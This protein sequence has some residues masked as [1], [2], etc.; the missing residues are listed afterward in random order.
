[1]S[2]I[3]CPQIA[4][5]Q[6][7]IHYLL[8]H[9][10][11][12]ELIDCPP[13]TN[14]TIELG[15]SLSP[16]FVCTPFKFTLGCMIESIYLGADT[17]IQM[18]GGCRYGYY[19]EL[20]EQII[21]DLGHEV[22]VYNLITAGK[23][24][25]K[26]IYNIFKEINP[27]LNI[28]KSLYYITITINMI[29]CM[30]KIDDFIRKNIGFE[31]NKN[32]FINLKKQMLQDFDKT[33]SNIN[34]FITYKKYQR[35]FKKLPINKSKDCLKIGIIGELYTVMEPFS[36]Y[37]IEYE[38]AKFNIEVKRFTNVNYLLFN[39]KRVTKKALKNNSFVKNKLTADASN[40]IY[41]AEYLCD[42]NYDGIIHIKSSFCTPEIGIIPIL[43]KIS[44]IKN[45]PIMFFSFD[46]NT[47]EVGIKT[48]LEAFNDMI[49]MRK[50][51]VFR[52]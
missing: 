12:S 19:S 44:N 36:N 29:K 7:P 3:A 38:L 10:T 37:F 16:E 1:M 40:N 43:N 20:Q 52:N 11:N 48:R 21:K 39:K 50:K 23:A 8:R 31:I 42:H 46:A 47:S 49:E 25:I 35:K 51:N 41:W 34:L 33:K 27:K 28:L 2:K 30:D 45:V 9:I 24:N 15:N 14:K 13:I 4:D 32:S 5:Y 6:I 17:L 22:K 18:G 26:R